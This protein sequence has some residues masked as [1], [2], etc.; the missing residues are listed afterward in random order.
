MNILFVCKHNKFRSK[1]A[2]SYFN[3]MNKNKKNK[4]KSAGIIKEYS[5]EKNTVKVLS[6]LGIKFE[7]KPQPLTKSLIKWQD[8]TII[9][10]DNVPK[11]IF[12]NNKFHGGNPEVWKIPDA[13]SSN[14][15]KIIRSTRM[16]MK[17]VDELLRR[18]G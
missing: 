18:L 15:R 4:A 7:G 6:K 14:N 2:E 1:V 9:A 12:S 17:N 10:A 11:S 5:Y 8:I 16:I 13:P 3:R